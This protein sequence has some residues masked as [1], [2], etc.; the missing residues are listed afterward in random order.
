MEREAIQDCYLCGKP[1]ASDTESDDHVVPKQ[2]LKRTQPK[3]KGFD[4]AG[5]LPAHASCNN[6]FGPERVG[7][8]ALALIRV[9]HDENCVLKRQHRDDPKI[10]ILAL[11]S[12]C[13]RNFTKSDL[14]FF[15]FIDVR[16]KD[17][18]KFS[19]PSF[20]QDKPKT[21]ALKQALYIAL[22]VLTKSAA[23]LLVSRHLKVVPP[24]WRVVAVP[25]FGK[26]NAVD[27][28]KLLGDTKPFDI[29]LK[30]WIRRM[31]KGDWLAI[32]KAR[33]VVLYLLFWFSGDRSHIEGIARIFREAD[34]LLFEGSKRWPRFFGHEIGPA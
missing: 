33:D 1:I 13:L 5:V 16:D 14:R 7:E 23:A 28:D 3:V 4:Y 26:D 32:Y 22:A 9:L 21:N 17:Y 30:V 34:Q 31:E 2:L 27:F 8:K 11:N 29:G 15:K 12:D 24:Q 18:A 10:V 19:N 20:F 6:E 25:Y